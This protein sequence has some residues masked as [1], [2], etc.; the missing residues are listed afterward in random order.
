M[1]SLL[2]EF[3]LCYFLPTYA[4]V[5]QMVGGLLYQPLLNLN[6]HTPPHAPD[7]LPPDV[8]PPLPPSIH[9]IPAHAHTAQQSQTRQRGQRHAH[10][11]VQPCPANL[12]SNRIIDPL[13]AY[14]GKDGEH[15]FEDK[16]LRAEEFPRNLAVA[17]TIRP[18]SA[19][20]SAGDTAAAT[21][22]T[23]VEGGEE[24]EVVTGR[25]VRGE[26]GAHEQDTRCGGK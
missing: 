18:G 3:H 15:A 13:G 14:R 11:S 9:D 20:S 23:G 4:S 17:G 26:I 6:A 16:G 1:D 2:A 8:N 5:K 7:N 22:T 10:I 24:R 19:A 21:A 25:V 12:T